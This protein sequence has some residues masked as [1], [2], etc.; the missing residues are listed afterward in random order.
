MT[1]LE[2]LLVKISSRSAAVGVIGLA[3]KPDIGDGRDFRNPAPYARARLVVDT[4][5]VVASSMGDSRVVRGV[6]DGISAR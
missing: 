4:R 2:N 1:Q 3:Y 5:N 6:V